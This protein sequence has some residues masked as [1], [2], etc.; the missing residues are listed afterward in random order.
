MHMVSDNW[1]NNIYQI[2]MTK[3]LKRGSP[4]KNKKLYYIYFSTS[5]SFKSAPEHSAPM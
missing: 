2:Q 4:V 3:F 5:A 1:I